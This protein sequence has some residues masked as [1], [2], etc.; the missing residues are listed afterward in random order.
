MSDTQEA[1]TA[2]RPTMID[3]RHTFKSYIAIY[4]V[5]QEFSHRD[6]EF[7]IELL[8]KNDKGL[9][10]DIT[11]WCE[12]TGNELLSFESEGEGGMRCLIQKGERRRNDKVMTVVMSTADLERVVYPFDKAIAGAVLGI[13]VN[14]VFEGAGVR[15]L[16]RGYRST[17]SGFL[18][19]LFTT[20]VENVMKKDIGWPLPKDAIE[21]L[22]ELGANFY[23]CG[24]SMVGY[25]V[26][27]EELIV[28]NFTLG[29]TIT[30]VDLLDRSDISVF[31]KAEFEKP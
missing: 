21:I 11:V 30:W 16:K 20:I 27:E 22:G 6:P 7:V 1:F 29:A 24:P 26:R 10:K 18:G 15:L 2:S 13:E 25:G 5:I 23:I 9:L 4:S 8:T 12:R 19:R 17:V 31:S 3:A 14:I 28:K